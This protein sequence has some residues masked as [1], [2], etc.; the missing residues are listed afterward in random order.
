MTPAYL[1]RVSVVW[2]RLAESQETG[3]SAGDS[4]AQTLRSEHMVS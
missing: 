1:K 2:D 4:L 3:T